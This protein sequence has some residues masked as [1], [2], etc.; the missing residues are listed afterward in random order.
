MAPMSV[1]QPRLPDW[2]VQNRNFVLLWCAYGVA[3]FG[4]HLSEMALLKERGGLSRPDVTRLQAIITFGFFLPFVVLGPIAGWW[5]DRASRKATMIAADVIRAVL[6]LN[7]AA[8]VGWLVA[9][10]PPAYADLSIILPLVGIGGLAAFFSPAR[11]A[12]LPTLVRDDQLVRANAMISGLGTIGA[13]ASAVVGGW[14][15]NTVGTG[16]NFRLNAVT[17][18]VSAACV[19]GIA[20]SRTRAV[21]HP[22]V[23]GVWKPVKAGFRYVREHRRVW[24]LILLGA[25]FWAGA[26]A[27][28]SVVPAVANLDFPEDYTAAGVFRGLLGI[29]LATGAVV[30]TLIGPALPVQLAVSTALLSACGW[31]LL[32]AVSVGLRLGPIVS[33]MCLF[34]I[35][36][37][38]SALL[39]TIMATIQRFVPDSR[40]GRVF[41]VSDMCTMGAMV[42]A[43]GLLGLPPIPEID[44]Y[45][46]ALLVG[47]AVMLGASLVFAMREYRRGDPHPLMLR[48][49][50]WAVMFYARFWLRVKRIGPCTVPREGPVILAANHTAGVDPMAI[51]ATCTHRLPSFMVAQEHYRVPIAHYFMSL[52]HSIPVDRSNP[53]RSALTQCVKHLRAGGCLGIF[54]QGTFETPG[55]STPDA[56]AGI[57]WIALRSGAVVVPAHISGTRY[58]DNP[59]RAYFMRHQM[60]IRYG[61]PIDLTRFEGREKARE[62]ADELTGLIMDEIRKLAPNSAGAPDP[63]AAAPVPG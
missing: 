14:L 26:G 52:A 18:L 28:I 40:R 4:D 62:A 10:L 50:W 51:Y 1:T 61:P 19:A 46:P 11:Q 2:L 53:G 13:I 38:G 59:F 43:T 33:G 39:V 23:E 12:M 60:R 22:P 20:M 56:K 9:A 54:P 29:G 36:G 55:D 7:L 58:T 25:I 21:P 3:A 35:G 41:G 8:I 27:V 5:S 31:M 45:I 6:V 42:L 57:G 32:L 24:Q 15:V 63:R 30:M 48:I 44:R 37:A 47:V 17:F 49:T 34:G 16:W